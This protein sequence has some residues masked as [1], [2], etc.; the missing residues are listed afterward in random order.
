MLEPRYRWTFPAAVVVDPAI[1]AEAT[2]AGLSARAVEVLVRRGLLD[3]AELRAFLAEPEAALHDPRLV[4]DAAAQARGIDVLV[5]DHHRVPPELP[6][7]VAV[8]N[9]HRPDSV[10]PDPRLSGSGVAFKVAQ[11]VLGG[12]PGGAADALGLAELAMIGTV[13][14]V[15]PVMGENRAIA[16]LGLARMRSEPRPGIAALLG[17]AGI[18]RSSIDLETI[19]FAIAP[20]INAAGRV[21][22][23]LDAARLLLTEDAAEAAELAERLEAANGTRRELTKVAL[24]EAQRLADTEPAGRG[25]IVVRG[26]W[27]V[28][29]VGLVASRLAE[30]RGRPAV[31]GANMRDATGDIVR[32]SCRSAGGVDLAAVLEGCRDL[33][34]RFEVERGRWDAVR[35]RFLG[36]VGDGPP[37]DQRPELALDLALPA[38]AVDYPLLRELALLAPTGPGNPEPLVAIFGLTATR[39]RAANGGHTQ[40]TLRRERDVLDSIAFGRADLAESVQEG[41]RVDVVARLAS[42]TFGGYESLQLEIRDVTTSGYH[43]AASAASLLQVGDSSGAEEPATIPAG[44]AS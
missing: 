35:E 38:A 24:E 11:L 9:P 1:S 13:S 5:T 27:P 40:L 22:E 37:A 8:V 39:V 17:R 36:L 21:G 12:L 25:A 29:I 20:R 19:A 31:V 15:A 18:A 32:A 16:R 34:V 6:P 41:D 7:A 28:G 30:D 4:P 44:A 10:Y 43:A 14:D 2:R 42:R 23:A 33:L 3:A 26:D